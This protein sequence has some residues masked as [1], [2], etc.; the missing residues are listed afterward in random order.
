MSLINLIKLTLNNN[1]FALLMCGNHNGGKKCSQSGVRGLKLL[2]DL[3]A[4]INEELSFFRFKVSE[5]EKNV[6]N[7]PL[8]IS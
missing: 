4:L 5:N 2:T 7:F 1:K 3:Q 6:K 8:F